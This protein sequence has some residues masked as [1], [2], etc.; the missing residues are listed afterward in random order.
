MPK[1]KLLAEYEA[2]IGPITGVSDEVFN[3]ARTVDYFKVTCE[4]GTSFHT[5]KSNLAA[6]FNRGNNIACAFCVNKQNIDKRYEE[7]EEK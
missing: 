3:N 7:K 4:C 6:R 2:E 5:K 1:K